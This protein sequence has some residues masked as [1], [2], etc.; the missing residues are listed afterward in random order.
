MTTE[1]VK[2]VA[3]VTNMR[4]SQRLGG[5]F[6]SAPV[7]IPLFDATAKFNSDGK[8]AVEFVW[9]PG[10]GYVPGADSHSVV[11]MKAAYRFPWQS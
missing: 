4:V 7:L 8:F 1:R 9:L 2:R 6:S 5:G 11:C 10:T 3:D